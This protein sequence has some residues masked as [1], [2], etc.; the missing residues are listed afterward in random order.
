MMEMLMEPYTGASL[1]SYGRS[2]ILIM[3]LL[4]ASRVLQ[5]L[6]RHRHF[7]LAS[8]GALD[9]GLIGG[10]GIAIQALVDRTFFVGRPRMVLLTYDLVWCAIGTICLGWYLIQA[11]KTLTPQDKMPP[12]NQ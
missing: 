6:A 5:L 7:A 1:T 4:L 12:S 8:K 10:V 11:I 9:V 2:F 3:I